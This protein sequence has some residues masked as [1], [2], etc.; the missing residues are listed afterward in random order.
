MLLGKTL[1]IMSHRIGN[2][3]RY[4]K[5]VKTATELGF[6]KIIV[7]RPEDVN[8]KSRRI[9]GFTFENSHWAKKH[10]DYPT[11]AH[12]IGYYSNPFLVSKV[13]KVK[14]KSHIPFVGYGLK[15]KWTIHSHLTR[16]SVL[17]PHIPFTIRLRDEAKALD[18]AKQ[19]GSVMIKPSNGSKGR[20]ISRL[21]FD[22]G[23][24]TFEQDRKV[25]LTSKKIIEKK[26]KEMLKKEKYIAQRWLDLRDHKGQVYDIRS[27]MQKDGTAEWH[28]SGMA[29]RRGDQG[30]IT[31]N[32]H[33]GGSAFKVLPFLAEQFSNEKAEE[34][35]KEIGRLSLYISSFLERSYRIQLAELGI[36]FAVDRKGNIWIIEV[37][38]KPGRTIL[39]YIYSH[40][41]YKNSFKAPIKY[42]AKLA[43]L[44]S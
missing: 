30:K 41:V 40:E 3:D 12:D 11:I 28:I 33:Q 15:N 18:I 44:Y 6:M 43:G 38:I 35:V 14:S 36:D 25:R 19:Y 7:F 27:L 26:I 16:S 2:L 31:S 39:K 37:N 1:G 42:A 23:T 34:L 9:H 29:V 21:S 32:L 8:T 13:F 4:L 17:L 22:N 20:G 5:Y 24:F 10:H